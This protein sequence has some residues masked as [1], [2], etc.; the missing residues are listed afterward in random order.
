MGAQ[1]DKAKAVALKILGDKGEVPDIGDAFEKARDSHEKAVEEFNKS[2]EDC[3]A[4]L[5][6]VQNTNDLG[7]KALKQLLA[8]IE[9]SDFNL[10]SKNKD[11]LKK[12]K[13]ARQFLRTS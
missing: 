10:N 11:D 8:K 9:K 13:E 6:A 12:I 4:K 7:D 2:R 3:E 5:L 1:W